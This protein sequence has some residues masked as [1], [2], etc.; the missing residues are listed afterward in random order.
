MLSGQVT[1]QKP[2]FL[3][4]PGFLTVTQLSRRSDTLYSYDAPSVRPVNSL[5]AQAQIGNTLWPIKIR[6][7]WPWTSVGPLQ[8]WS[9]STSG[10]PR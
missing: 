8:T 5:K 3:K 2:G 1:N 7:C 9:C 4:K 6:L 10:L